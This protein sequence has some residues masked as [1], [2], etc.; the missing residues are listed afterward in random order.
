[1]FTQFGRENAASGVYIMANSLGP[2]KHVLMKKDEED[3]N[4]QDYCF[5]RF[6]N[7]ES[8][9]RALAHEEA[10]VLDFMIL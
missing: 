1:M 4:T 8:V 10:L 9:H 6:E 7:E 5:V 3:K 2:V